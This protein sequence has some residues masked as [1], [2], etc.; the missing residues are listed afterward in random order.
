[1]KTMLQNSFKY[2]RGVMPQKSSPMNIETKDTEPVTEF[3]TNIATKCFV[4][5]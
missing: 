4:I 2:V 1:M 5:Q 3:V